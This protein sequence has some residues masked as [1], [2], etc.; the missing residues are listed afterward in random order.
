MNARTYIQAGFLALAFAS[1]SEAGNRPSLGDSATFAT[2]YDKKNKTLN[3]HV[4]LRDGV[5][6]YAPGETTGKP[7]SLVVKPQNGWKTSG[8]VQLPRGKEKSLKTF[9]KSIIIDGEFDVKTRVEGGSGPILAELHLQVCSENACD[10]PRVHPF[11][12]QVN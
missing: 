9:G 8:D 5:H 11:E 10:R 2:A 6:A 1:A 12:V 4:K 3:V 7:V